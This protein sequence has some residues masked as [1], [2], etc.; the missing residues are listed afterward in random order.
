[1]PEGHLL[2]DH[3]AHRRSRDV[4]APDA[5]LVHQPGHVLGHVRHRIGDVRSSALSRASIVEG[6]D[7]ELGGKGGDVERP[8][9]VV[10]APAHDEDE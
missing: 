10:A 5:Q 7:V 2:G 6:D 3:A 4:R 9:G 8:G 1:M